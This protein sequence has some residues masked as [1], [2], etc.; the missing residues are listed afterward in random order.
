MNNEQATRPVDVRGVEDN[1]LDV[2]MIMEALAQDKTD[3]NVT[4]VRDG[5]QALA[6]LHGEGE[7]AEAVR[8]DIILLDWRLPKKHGREVLAEIRADPDLKLIPVIV[9]TTSEAEQDALSAYRL[10]ANCF[11]TKPVDPEEFI[12]AVQSIGDL[13]LPF[14]KSPPQ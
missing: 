14:V 5:E 12:A 6:F 8:P 7:Y 13:W 2:R 11:V 1:P 10:H 4:V 3:N 9:L